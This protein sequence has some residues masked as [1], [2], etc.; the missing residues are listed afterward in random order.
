VLGPEEFVLQPEFALLE[1]TEK[2]L[3]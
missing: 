2:D 3:L 1:G